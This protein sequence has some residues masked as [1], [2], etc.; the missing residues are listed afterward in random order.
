MTRLLKG[1]AVKVRLISIKLTARRGSACLMAR[2]AVAPAKPPPITSTRGAAWA[3]AGLPIPATAAAPAPS[4]ARACRRLKRGCAIS[5]PLISGQ[6]TSRRW[7]GF[8][9]PKS[10]WRCD[11]SPCPGFCPLL[12]ACMPAA[13]SAALRP[14]SRGTAVSTR[15]L[16][17]MAAGTGGRARRRLGPPRR[18]WHQQHRCDHKDP[19]CTHGVTPSEGAA[20][21]QPDRLLLASSIRPGGSFRSSAAA[22]GRAC[23]SPQSRR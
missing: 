21:Q 13:S 19:G 11:P 5:A 23:P 8:P 10:P 6:R 14:I 7:L 12:K 4:A 20:E 18:A 15:A 22:C 17:R 9:R 1:Q 16:R 2:A 3:N